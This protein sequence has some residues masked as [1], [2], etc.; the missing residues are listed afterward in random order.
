[1]NTPMRM[2]IAAPEGP[3]RKRGRMVSSC[4]EE[5]AVAPR[6]KTGVVPD[7]MMPNEPLQPTIVVGRPRR[8]LPPAPAADR[9]IVGQE[10]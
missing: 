3:A 4:G 6:W 7:A 2:A 5:L 9:Q 8:G 1:M 10:K